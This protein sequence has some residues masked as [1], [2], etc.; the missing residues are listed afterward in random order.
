M[1]WFGVLC[2]VLFFYSV[3][4]E[5]GNLRVGWVSIHFSVNKLSKACSHFKTHKSLYCFAS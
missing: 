5:F 1:L 3:G 4:F 2:F